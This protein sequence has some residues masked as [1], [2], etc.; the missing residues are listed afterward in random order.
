MQ[1][2]PPVNF[3]GTVFGLLQS[4]GLSVTIAQK[5]VDSP[6]TVLQKITRSRPNQINGLGPKSGPAGKSESCGPENGVSRWRRSNTDIC[7]QNHHFGLVCDMIYQFI[8]MDAKN[9]KFGMFCQQ[10]HPSVA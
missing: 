3:T 2:M 6:N 9:Y 7:S 4:F 10:C 1:K 8:G 5:T